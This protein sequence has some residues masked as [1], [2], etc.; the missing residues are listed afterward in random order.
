MAE[1]SRRIQ[2][3]ERARLAKQ[4]AKEYERGQ[5]IRQLS[6]QHDL[7]IGTVRRLL[8]EQGVTFRARGGADR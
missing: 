1:G 2:G 4:L 5:S 3:Q 6:G 8:L 7:S